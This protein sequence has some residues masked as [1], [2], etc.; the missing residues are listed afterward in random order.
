M[1]HIKK[2]VFSP[3]QENTYVISDDDKNAIIIDPGCYDAEEKKNLKEFIERQNLTPIRLLNTHCH[4]DHVF[5]NAFVY[6]EWNLQPEYHRLE[7]QVMQMAGRSADMYGIPGFEESPEPKRFLKED[8][9]L[10]FGGEQFQLLF[11][12]GHSPGHLG[13]YCAQL[14]MLISGDVIFR[15]SIGRTDL[16]GGNQETLFQSIREKIYPLPD[17]TQIFNGHGP[18]T[19]VGHEKKSNPFVR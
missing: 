15:E 19:T 11:L 6:K 5:G 13:F 17:E 8:E 1:V 9:I 7:T 18:E 10:E 16:P 2:F 4:L 3:F 12:P 14:N